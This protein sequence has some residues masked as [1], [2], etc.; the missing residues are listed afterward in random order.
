MAW[1]GPRMEAKLRHWVEWLGW[2]VVVI[3]VV[4]YF[5]FRK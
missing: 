5:Y 2:L 3:A 1:G 4:A